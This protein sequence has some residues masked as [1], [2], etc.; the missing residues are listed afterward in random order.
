MLKNIEDIL[1]HIHAKNLASIS[2]KG[3][4]SSIARQTLRR[5]ALTDRQFDLAKIKIQPYRE[6]LVS[7]FESD[8]EF[9]VAANTLRQ[10]LRSV[11]R[12]KLVDITVDGMICVRFPFNKKTITALEEVATKLRRFYKHERGSHEHFFKFN[13]LTVEAVVEQFKDRNFYICEELIEH[14]HKVKEIKKTAQEVLPGIYNGELRNFRTAALELMERELGP[15]QAENEL[16]YF[17]RRERY[18]IA[19]FKFE[20]PAGVL[21]ELLYRESGQVAVKPSEYSI[22]ETLRA[23]LQLRRLPLLVLIDEEQALT[24]VSTVYNCLSGV[25]PNTD[26]SCLFRIENSNKT[27]YNL[28]TFIKDI[29]LNNWLDKD[30]KVVYISKNKLPKLL[31][32]TDW[33]PM[34]VIGLTSLR[35]NSSVQTYALDVTDMVVFYDE[36]LGLIRKTRLNG[37]Y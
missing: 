20:K 22:D 6:H 34:A 23:I 32:K 9:E 21:G 25:V 31:L 12:S 19:H 7:L 4:L 18:G 28:N 13:E 27:E 30:T 11:D 17:D 14:Y 1:E 36:E 24:Q 8:T 5:T 29:R 16:F 15:L 3:I 35:A 10:P 2:D 37:Y 33:R 26:Q